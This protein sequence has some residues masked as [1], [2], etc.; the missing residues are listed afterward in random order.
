MITALLVLPRRYIMGHYASQPIEIA[1]YCLGPVHTE[2]EISS[3]VWP[4]FHTYS[5][6]TV[7]ENAFQIRA[8][9][10]RRYSVLVWMVGNGD[11]S[12]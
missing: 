3:S 10:K 2:P 9:W 12:I 7:P 8:F 5:V 11:L 4:T 1:V 6:K